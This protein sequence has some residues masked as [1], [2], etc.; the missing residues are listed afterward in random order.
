[1]SDHLSSSLPP[2]K[3]DVLYQKRA[4]RRSKPSAPLMC[5][6]L[7]DKQDENTHPIQIT[8]LQRSDIGKIKVTNAASSGSGS[9]AMPHRM[10][11]LQLGSRRL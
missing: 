7:R 1:M 6:L 4:D 3:R 8:A 10:R 9:P 2:R 5:G 11:D